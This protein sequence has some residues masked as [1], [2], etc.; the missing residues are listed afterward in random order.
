MNRKAFIFYTVCWLIAMAQESAKAQ[1]TYSLQQ[2][3]ETALKQSLQLKA[4][5][6]DLDKTNASI[7]QAYS[8]LL[9]SISLNGS[10]Q[11]APQVQASIIPAETFGGPA[12]S[13]TA[14]RLGVHQT[15]YATAELN[16]NLYNASAL[17]GL[18]AAKILVTGNQLQIRSSQEDLVYNVSAT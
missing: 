13:Y 2:C 18:K 10:Y 7:S 12:G 1:Q 9:P 5:A 11:Y 4:D 16:Q 14:A 6:L 3:I 15:K 8:S 17:I